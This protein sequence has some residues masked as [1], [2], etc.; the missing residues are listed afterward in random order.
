MTVI[1]GETVRRTFSKRAPNLPAACRP[2]VASSLKPPP[3]A[4]A[5][6]PIAEGALGRRR[7]ASP[8]QR[9]AASAASQR[10]PR[11][12]PLGAALLRADGDEPRQA[13]RGDQG[14]GGDPLLPRARAAAHA[15]PGGALGAARVARADGLRRGSGDPVRRGPPGT[16]RPGR[17]GLPRA[18][19]PD[20]PASAVF[21]PSLR[22]SPVRASPLLQG[23]GPGPLR[24]RAHA[25]QRLLRRR[26]LGA[27]ARAL[28]PRPPRRGARLGQPCASPPLSLSICDSGSLRSSPSLYPPACRPF[29]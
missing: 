17:P 9:P 6:I 24:P 7:E 29:H 19:A 15:R 8:R 22:P 4:F 26:G 13:H 5:A 28:H 1:V 3:C 12:P 18:P 20:G 2:P 16:S 21:G 11:R 14:R 23:G 27:P 25:E 10:R